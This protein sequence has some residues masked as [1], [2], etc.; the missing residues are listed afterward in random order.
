[1][2]KHHRFPCSLRLLELLL[3]EKCGVLC[4]RPLHPWFRCWNSRLK[5]C[6]GSCSALTV[7]RCSTEDAIADELATCFCSKC[8]RIDSSKRSHI[9][10]SFEAAYNKYI[11]KNII[12]MHITSENAN[13]AVSNSKSQASGLDGSSIELF[14]FVHPLVASAWLY[15]YSVWCYVHVYELLIVSALVLWFVTQTPCR[16]C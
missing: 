4:C 9:K 14:L 13:A 3:S 7:E 2:L 8:T 12:D 16:R 10:N 11:E 5:G 15:T 6:S 1:M